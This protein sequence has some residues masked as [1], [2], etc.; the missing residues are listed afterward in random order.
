MA[1]KVVI[2][3]DDAVFRDGIAA[4]LRAAGIETATFP[5]PIDAIDAARLCEVLVTRISFRPGLQGG[6]SLARMAQARRKVKVLFIGAGSAPYDERQAASELGELLLDASA[7][8][9]VGAVR[10][11]LGR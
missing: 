10:Q 9:V 3:H 4:H 2:V 8:L 1:A 5:I 11:L 7:A 6:L